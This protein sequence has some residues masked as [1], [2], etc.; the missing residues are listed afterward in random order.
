[1]NPQLKKAR[2]WF[3]GAAIFVAI[4]AI[5]IAFLPK[6]LPSWEGILSEES[7]E[8]DKCY[9]SEGETQLKID[10]EPGKWS[11]WVVT[12]PATN[13]RFDPEDYTKEYRVKFWDGTLWVD[14]PDTQDATWFGIKRGIFKFKSEEAMTIIVT[15]EQ[16]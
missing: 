15:I 8:Y 7:T 1:M 13:Y 4:I 5:L 10:L 16:Q 2:R 6:H 12:P 9:F 14:K 11:C 3:S